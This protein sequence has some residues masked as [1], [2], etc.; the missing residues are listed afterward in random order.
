M[1][2]VATAKVGQPILEHV[3]TADR[4]DH[5]D[6]ISSNPGRARRYGLMMTRL[7]IGTRPYRSSESEISIRMH[8]CDAYVPIDEEL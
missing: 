7:P 6:V 8:P 3:R 1:A 5:R 4:I 2:A